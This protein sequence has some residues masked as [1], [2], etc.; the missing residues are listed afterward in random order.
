MLFRFW[1]QLKA[2][3]SIV[4]SSRDLAAGSDKVGAL[5]N[6]GVISD[7]LDDR[8]FVRSGI[9]NA[10]A[11]AGDRIADE[12]ITMAAV[13][14]VDDGRQNG[15]IEGKSQQHAANVLHIRHVSGEPRRTVGRRQRMLE[16]ELPRP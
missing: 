14:P 9:A 4:R 7:H 12:L 11:P 6:P 15:F 13:K 16:G 2:K 3:R 5:L 10:G 1:L 8:Q